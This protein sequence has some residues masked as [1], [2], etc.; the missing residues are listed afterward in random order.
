M[1]PALLPIMLAGKHLVLAANQ[2]PQFD[3]DPSCHAAA[4]AAIT[5]K[6]NEIVCKPDERVAR[7]KL[8]QE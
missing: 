7:G 3:I 5:V 6:R 1:M 4:M 2:V 8:E